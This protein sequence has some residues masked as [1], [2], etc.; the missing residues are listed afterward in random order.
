MATPSFAAVVRADL[1]R[2]ATANC[3]EVAKTYNISIRPGA[4]SAT[5]Q[6]QVRKHLQQFLGPAESAKDGASADHTQG[7]GAAARSGASEGVQLPIGEAGCLPSK[8]LSFST[9]VQSPGGPRL[10][11]LGRVPKPRTPLTSPDAVLQETGGGP[12]SGPPSREQGEALDTAQ[13]LPAA[14]VS[15]AA[16]PSLEQRVAEL[17]AAAAARDQRMAQLEAHRAG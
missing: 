15:D 2:L 6:C 8:R 9:V 12:A 16:R 1:A 7:S 11:P 17:E 10:T 4:S 14:A 3:K 5:I 13:Q